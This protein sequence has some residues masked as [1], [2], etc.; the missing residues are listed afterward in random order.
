MN[1]EEF[2]T[3]LG[4]AIRQL[5]ET[6][7]WTQARLGSKVG[8]HRNTVARYE[9]GEDIPVMVFVRICTALGSHAK[10]VLDSVLPDAAERIA[11]ANGT[12]APAQLAFRDV[13]E[14]I[15]VK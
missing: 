8:I 11:A 3:Q 10:D 2:Q 14:D 15:E 9:G 4:D 6:K 5:R 1:Q 7:K 13:A 12:A